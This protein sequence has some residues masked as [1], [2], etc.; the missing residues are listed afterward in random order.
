MEEFRQAEVSCCLRGSDESQSTSQPRLRGSLLVPHAIG[1]DV[2]SRA[3][4]W[5]NP[6]LSP[7]PSDPWHNP[8]HLQPNR[9]PSRCCPYSSG[10]HSEGLNPD[11]APD[12]LVG[13]SKGNHLPLPQLGHGRVSDSSFLRGL[14]LLPPSRAEDGQACSHPI[15]MGLVSSNHVQGSGI[16]PKITASNY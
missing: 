16:S 4:S 15:A 3:R 2:F 5:C 8:W 7:C 12:A 9:C 1:E 13:G 11:A 10:D 14:T 6:P